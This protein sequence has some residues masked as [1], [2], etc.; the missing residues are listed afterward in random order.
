M[1]GANQL[2]RKPFVPAQAGTPYCS[3]DEGTDGMSGTK[4]QG[5]RAINLAPSTTLGLF[6]KRYCFATQ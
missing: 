1:V 3:T 5:D 4:S 6:I 2:Q